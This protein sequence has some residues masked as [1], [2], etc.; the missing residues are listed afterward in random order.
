[1]PKLESCYISASKKVDGR[2]QW[3]EPDSFD[4]Q[5]MLFSQCAC[6]PFVSWQQSACSLT[7]HLSYVQAQPPDY[8]TRHHNHVCN[9]SAKGANE[10]FATVQSWRRLSLVSFDVGAEYQLCA[11]PIVLDARVYVIQWDTTLSMM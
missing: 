2:F 4:I 5:V 8:V 7:R 10:G 1:L 9:Q 11:Y 6:I 3:F